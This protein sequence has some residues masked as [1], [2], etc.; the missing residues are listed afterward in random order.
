MVIEQGLRQLVTG[1]VGSVRDTSNQT[2]PLQQLEVPVGRALGKVRLDGEQL[3]QGERA[4]C[5]RQ[6]RHQKAPPGR[7]ALVSRAEPIEHTVGDGV[8]LPTIEA[9]GS[10]L[11]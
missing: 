5:D 9:V 6:G 10:L 11:G 3:G 4:A 7:V 2:H 1:M 8:E